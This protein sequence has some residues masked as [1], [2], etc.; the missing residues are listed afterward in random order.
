MANRR[1]TQFFYTLHQKPV[2]LDCNFVVDST[3]G[4]GLGIRNLKG[5]GIGAV[6]MH[7]SASVAAGSPNP[8]A[9]VALIYLQDNYNRYFGGTFGFSSPLTGSALTSVTQHTSYVI[10]S[11]GSTT[12]A[13]WATAGV[14]VGT[15]P[16]LGVGFVATATGSIGGTGT[17]QAVGVS[18]ISSIEVMGDPNTTIKS[19][20][21]QILGST[22]GSY[23][24]IQFLAATS[25]SVTTVIPTAPANGTVVQL[26]FYL[27]NSGLM[28]AG[29]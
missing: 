6:Y 14:P 28:N 4:N 8:A 10:T 27:S 16:A 18:G 3:N 11:L 5:P 12:A 2:L 19:T 7:T 29:E 22:S 20:A 24:M 26:S 25:T 9:G 21:A 17:V 13:Q 1:F 15:V 23:L